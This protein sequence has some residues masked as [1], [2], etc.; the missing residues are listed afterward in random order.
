MFQNLGLN[1]G[2]TQR[3]LTLFGSKSM[4]ARKI[5]LAKAVRG[6]AVVGVL[7]I[8]LTASS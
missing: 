1:G 7:R 6:E 2:I 4:N 5:V 3:P 8:S